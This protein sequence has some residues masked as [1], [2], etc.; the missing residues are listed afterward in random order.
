MASLLPQLHL[1]VFLQGPRNRGGEYVCRPG[2]EA[3]DVY[4]EEGPLVFRQG[5]RYDSCAEV[6][7]NRIKRSSSRKIN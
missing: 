1:G 7:M 6:E 5:L 4:I 3:A 2:R